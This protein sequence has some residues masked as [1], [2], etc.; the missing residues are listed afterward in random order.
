MVENNAEKRCGRELQ[1]FTAPRTS[2]VMKSCSKADLALRWQ[3]ERW[4]LKHPS[5]PAFWGS[6]IPAG[7]P[8]AIEKTSWVARSLQLP[9][10]WL[11]GCCLVLML[12]GPRLICSQW[13]LMIH[14]SR[15]NML[16]QSLCPFC[17]RADKWGQQDEEFVFTS[18]SPK[19]QKK[20][21]AC[22]ELWLQ[23]DAV[24]LG[25]DW[26]PSPLVQHF[27]KAEPWR[28]CCRCIWN[29]R[30]AALWAEPPGTTG[31][32]QVTVGSAAPA[33]VQR[34]GNRKTQN[35][36]LTGAEVCLLRSHQWV[37]ITVL[38]SEPFAV[39]F[40]WITEIKEAWQELQR[41]HPAV[42]RAT[43]DQAGPGLKQLKH[44]NQSVTMLGCITACPFFPL[45]W[46]ESL[47]FVSL[48]R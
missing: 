22:G 2:S 41:G 5:S 4:P 44:Q 31:Y 10:Q 9:E 32:T 34:N 23:G 19:L 25:E 48:H 17:R 18:S 14:G 6:D 43:P 42:P 29:S 39:H 40:P 8:G 1:P 7:F 30:A 33:L 20:Q 13:K 45:Q 16:C 27:L 11:E 3:K 24:Y 35:T 46:Q 26:E 28:R 47:D 21:N 15:W 37:A 12:P 36:E 38:L